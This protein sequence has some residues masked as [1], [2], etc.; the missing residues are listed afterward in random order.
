MLIRSRD[1]EAIFAGKVTAAFRRWK[2]PTLKAGGTPCTSMGLLAI[3]A[4]E[5][6]DPARR[7]EADARSAGV[8]L[9][10][11]RAVLAGREGV[12]T[13]IRLRPG[14]P[15]PHIALQSQ[16]EMSRLANHGRALCLM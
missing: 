8:S 16:T 10:E 1:L 4:V 12:C 3:D 5:E 2:R 13:R 15:D 14:G 11:L 9:M 7:G 6:V